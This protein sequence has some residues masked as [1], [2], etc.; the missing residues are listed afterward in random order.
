M[1]DGIPVSALNPLPPMPQLSYLQSNDKNETHLRELLTHDD[2]EGR[3][4]DRQVT[5]KQKVLTIIVMV[6]SCCACCCYDDDYFMLCD[7]GHVTKSS[8][9]WSSH[10]SK[11]STISSF[12]FE[13]LWKG[14]KNDKECEKH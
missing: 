7:L 9:V 11:G 2:N 14:Q 3:T 13:K 8:C 4:V 10:L 5:K 12:Y 1:V 6:V